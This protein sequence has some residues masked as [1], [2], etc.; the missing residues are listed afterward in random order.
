[1]AIWRNKRR[2]ALWPFLMCV[3]LVCAARAETP[4]SCV[5]CHSALDPPCKVTQEQL[6][7]EIH[8]QKGLTCASCHGGD[9]SKDDQDAMSKKAG[10]RG[11]IEHNQVPG[12]CGKC[13][14]DAAFMR[15]Y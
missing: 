2:A 13:H 8:A 9:P 3:V 6:S 10:F 14:S 1:M 15:Q 5:D 7:Q 4:D 12:L 11:K